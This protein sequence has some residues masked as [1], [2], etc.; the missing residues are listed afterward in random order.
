MRLSRYTVMLDACVLYPAPLRDLLI[1]LASTD[2]FRAKWTQRIHD[3]WVSS[4]LKNR[5]DLDEQRLRNHTIARMNDA[6]LNGLVSG[7]EAIEAGLELPD[8]N[9]N[10]VLAAAIHSKCDAIVTFNLRDFPR[11]QLDRYE[12]ELLHPDDF[13]HFQYDLGEADV[14]T[15]V[16]RLRKRLRKPPLTVGEYLGVLEAQG[17]PKTVAALRKF[18]KVL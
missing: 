15:S 10:H 16:Q 7:Y 9:D 11:E 13:L 17:L 18:E 12:I 6:V 8:T 1:E 4:L 14:V 2:L 3:E 5:P